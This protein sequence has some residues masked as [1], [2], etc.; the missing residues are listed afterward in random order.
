MLERPASQAIRE[1]R[2][3]KDV[4][5]ALGAPY[6]GKPAVSSGDLAGVSFNIRLSSRVVENEESMRALLAQANPLSFCMRLARSTFPRR[7]LTEETPRRAL[8][9]GGV[10]RFVPSTDNP[11]NPTNVRGATKRAA[12]ILLIDF[13]QECV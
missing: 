13:A 4:T 12:E 1:V 6:K 11:I 5:E 3:I 9:G 2:V 7:G 10:E 8:R